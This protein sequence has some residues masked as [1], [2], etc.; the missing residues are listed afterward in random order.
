MRRINENTVVLTDME[1][2]AKDLFDQVLDAG[3]GI[4]TAASLV[5]STFPLL[6]VDDPSFLVWLEA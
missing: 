2:K 1:S 6:A 3:C 4:P 5:K